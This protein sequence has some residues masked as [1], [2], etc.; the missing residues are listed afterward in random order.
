M[1]KTRYDTRVRPGHLFMIAW[2]WSDI[3]P[4]RPSVV[5]ETRCS[6]YWYHEWDQ[7]FYLLTLSETRSPFMT[8]SLRPDVLSL[9]PRVFYCLTSWV[10]PGALFMTAWMRPDVL[11]IKTMSETRCFIVWHHEWDQMFYLWLHEWDQVLYLWLHEWDQMF[12][13]WDHERPDALLIE[14]MSKIRCFIID[15][16]SVT[17]YLFIDIMSATMCSINNTMNETACSIY[18]HHEWLHLCDP[19]LAIIILNL[20][21]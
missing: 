4:L 6:I 19:L 1:S 9:R 16:M 2:M 3:L 14:T 17:R 21:P 15:I 13:H 12:V 7:M 18:W 5:S 11:L 10:R 20:M 8:E